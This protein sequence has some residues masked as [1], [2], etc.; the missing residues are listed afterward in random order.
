MDKLKHLLE[1]ID[2]HG[3]KA[4]KQ[5]QGEYYFP[6][7]L[8][9]IDHVQGDPFADP[10]RCRVFI[11]K[12][13]IN[14]NKELYGNRIRRITLEDYLGRRI[15]AAIKQHV[16]GSRGAGKSGEMFIVRYGQ[17]VLERNSVLV[18][19]GDV[20]VR[21]QIGLP[22]DGRS[23]NGRQAK[24]MLFEELVNVVQSG[25]LLVQD[26]PDIVQRHVDSVEDQH[27]LREQLQAKELVAFIADS[28]MLPRVSGV[29]DRPLE[30]AVR[31]CAPNSLAVELD[32]LH[33]RPLRGLGVSKGITLIVGGGYHGKS[34]LLHAIERGVY[35]HIPGDGRECVVTDPSA[36]KIRAE[37][38]RAIT[39]IDI[40]PFI[41]NLPQGKDTRQFSTQNASGSTSQAANIIEALAS[42]VQT[43]LI[44][45]DTSATNFMIRDQRMQALVAKDKEPITPLVQRIQ[46]LYQNEDVSVVLVMGGSGDYFDVADTVIMMDNYAPRDVTDE[47]KAL[48]QGSAPREAGSLVIHAHLRI[49]QLECLNP[50]LREGKEKIQAFEMRALRYGRQEIDLSRVEQLVDSAQLR[51]IGFLIRHYAKQSSR[52]HKDLVSGLSDALEEVESHGLDQITPYIIGTLAIP[53]FQELVAVVNRMRGLELIGMDGQMTN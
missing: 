23:V 41:N 12:A 48:A 1:Q 18:R 42:G 36:F 20:E 47:A 46:D 33:G 31:F 39:G 8:L 14:L 11:K 4:Y 35:N 26:E 34:T 49:P 28:S 21:L 9:R 45:E 44:D 19:N 27:H 3:Y 32:R 25:L 50:K 22:V 5:L 15:E 17:Q 43:L 51:A 37:D 13:I 24:V 16:Q 10:S 2:H 53:R 6:D 29:D 40:S 7:F 30:E 52:Q 38:G